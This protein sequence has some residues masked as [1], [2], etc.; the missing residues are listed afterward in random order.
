MGAP[1]L[2]EPSKQMKQQ[3]AGSQKEGKNVKEVAKTRSRRPLCSP[4]SCR[5][6]SAHVTLPAAHQ[7]SVPIALRMETRI[8]AVAGGCAPCLLSRLVS[9]CSREEEGDL[10]EGRTDPAA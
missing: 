4:G 8:S 9:P 2:S 3:T 1:P 6:P 7:G 5:H 10:G